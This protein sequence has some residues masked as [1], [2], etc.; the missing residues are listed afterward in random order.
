M[1]SDWLPVYKI[2]F[3]SHMR[4]PEFC[5]GHWYIVRVCLFLEAPVDVGWQVGGRV[6]GVVCYANVMSIFF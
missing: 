6:G 3:P 2:P 1:L 5:C 4:E